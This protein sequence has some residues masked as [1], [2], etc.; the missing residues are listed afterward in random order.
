MFIA[1]LLTIIKIWKQSKCLST[2][3]WRKIL[4]IYICYIY[5]TYKICIC[6]YIHIIYSTYNKHIYVYIGASLVAQV[7]KNSPA[8]ET[9]VRSLGWEDPLE[10]GMAI[11][12]SILA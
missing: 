8:Q 5:S 1:P 12:P 6:L 4:Y 9:P 7:V 10:K 3:E 11:H 2:D